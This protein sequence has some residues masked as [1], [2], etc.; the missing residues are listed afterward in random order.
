M[1]C[2]CAFCF[3]SCHHNQSAKSTLILICVAASC[4]ILHLWLLNEWLQSKMT[5]L[6]SSRMTIT[7]QTRD[8]PW[9]CVH[10]LIP[11]FRLDC[12]RKTGLSF[13]NIKIHYRCLLFYSIESKDALT[14]MSIE[15]PFWKKFLALLMKDSKYWRMFQMMLMNSYERLLRIMDV[16]LSL[17][18]SGGFSFKFTKFQI[19]NSQSLQSFS[20]WEL[21]CRNS[22]LI[23]YDLFMQSPQLPL[24][25]IDYSEIHA[26]CARSLVIM[27]C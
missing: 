9:I 3:L 22:S 6:T 13:L 8:H 11:W 27:G 14:I 21:E 24:T 7:F 2:F 18:P 4:A 10:C 20:K 19:C 25:S 1:V 12:L 26:R 16:R 15:M 5:N 17:C 23:S